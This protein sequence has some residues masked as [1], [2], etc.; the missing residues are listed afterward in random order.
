LHYSK[1]TKRLP[2]NREP[3]RF[4]ACTGR[5]FGRL[6]LPKTVL[7]LSNSGREVISRVYGATD[8][9]VVQGL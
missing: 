9:L 6:S 5:R 3:F 1:K 8:W 7:A 4:R 2:R